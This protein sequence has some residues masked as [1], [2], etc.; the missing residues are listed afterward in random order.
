MLLT[1]FP[2]VNTIPETQPEL[3]AN[4]SK[5]TKA[6]RVAAKSK[7]VLM[8]DH[9]SEVETD[10]DVFPLT[11]EDPKDVQVVDKE[12]KDMQGETEGESCCTLPCNATQNKKLCV[13]RIKQ[14]TIRWHR[15]PPPKCE[16][17]GT[18]FCFFPTFA[19]GT[20]ISIFYLC[21]KHKLV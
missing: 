12:A 17:K 20:C 1:Y 5:K 15:P 10:S 6:Q 4:V 16:L 11:Q 21:R 14:K 19:H 8:E 2:D 9:M 3:I 18:G 7:T 13:K